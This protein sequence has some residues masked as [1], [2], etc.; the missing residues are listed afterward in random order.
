[1]N[2]DHLLEFAL[3]Q[4]PILVGLFIVLL[5]IWLGYEIGRNNA[6]AVTIHQLTSLV[7]QHEGVVVDL[8]D[9]NAFRSGHISGAINIPAASLATRTSELERF[10]ERPII[11]VCKMGQQSGAAVATL[12]KAGFKHVARLRGGVDQWQAENLPLVKK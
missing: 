7:N 2:I 6:N 9:A 3:H 10:K 4:H 5:L 1:M 11:V 8:R 12:K